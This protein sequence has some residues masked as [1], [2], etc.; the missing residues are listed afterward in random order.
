MIARLSE[1][2]RQT[3]DDAEAWSHL[4]VLLMSAR[5]YK[6]AAEALGHASELTPGS[7]RL[8]ARY[9]EALVFA[10]EGKVGAAARGVFESALLIDR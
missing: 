10:A 6:P 2:L 1:R 3:P 5:R 7:A 8:M 9:G 4:G